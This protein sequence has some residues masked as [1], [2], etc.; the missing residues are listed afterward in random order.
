MLEVPRESGRREMLRRKRLLD[1]RLSS[2]VGSRAAY[3]HIARRARRVR[4]PGTVAQ[5]VQNHPGAYS[6][7]SSLRVNYC[8]GRNSN[9]VSTRATLRG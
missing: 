2:V 7:A 9:A 6:F 8:S 4:H 5:I 1:R 3:P